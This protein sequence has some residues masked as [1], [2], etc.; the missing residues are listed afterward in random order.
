MQIPDT[1]AEKPDTSTEK[2][3][4]LSIKSK[5]CLEKAMML[6]VEITEIIDG[7]Q[8]SVECIQ[9][10]STDIQGTKLSPTMLMD[11][12]VVLDLS[13]ISS[14]PR[15]QATPS[16][17]ELAPSKS[18]KISNAKKESQPAKKRQPSRQQISRIAEALNPPTREDLSKRKLF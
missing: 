15:I 10:P 4:T 7:S 17:S 3:N 12:S 2:I 18:T 11:D 8:Q 9:P 5:A 1:S 16:C 14:K 13:L 6:N